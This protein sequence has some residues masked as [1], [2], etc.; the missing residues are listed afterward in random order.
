MQIT[1]VPN[2]TVLV[3]PVEPVC[4][5][6]RFISSITAFQAFF[7]ALFCGCIEPPQMV[8]Y[9]NIPITPIDKPIFPAQLATWPSRQTGS[10]G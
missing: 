8:F 2:G 5:F 10:T 4:Q 7:P 1:T 3:L 6:S 9:R